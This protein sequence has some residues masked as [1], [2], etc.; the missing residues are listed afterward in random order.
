M[1]PST[2]YPISPVPF[3]DVSI[4]DAFWQP[5]LETNRKV[6][7]PYCFQKC[8]ET[9]R[10]ANFDKAAGVISGAHEG[11]FFNDS[12]V[13]KVLEGAAYALALAPD[14]ELDA[15]VDDLIARIEAAQEEDG[16]LYTART[17][18]PEAVTAESEGLTRW[19]N[20]PVNHELYNVGHMYEAAVAHF[21]AT[22]KRN[23]LDIA[24]RNAD[25]ID[26]VFGPDGIH[27]VP[28]HQEIEL[29][30]VKLYLVTGEQKYLN[31]AYFFLDQRGRHETRD[32]VVRFEN[33]GY[34]QD[35]LPVKEQASAV[36]HAVRAGYMYA[37]MA[38]V[39]ALC[40]EESWVKALET[41]WQDVVQGK[42]YLNGGIGARHQ[43]EAFGESFELPNDTGYAETCAAISNVYW[44]HRMFLLQGHAKA[45]DVLELSLYNGVLPGISLEGTEFFYSNPLYSD[46]EWEFNRG[47]IG[48]QP[49]FDCSCCPTNLVRFLPA[50]PGWIYATETDRIYVNLYVGSNTT[51]Q[52]PGTDAVVSLTQTTNYPWQGDVNFK[53]QLEGPTRFAL[54]LRVPGWLQEP[55]PGGLYSYVGVENSSWDLQRN[56]KRVEGRVEKGY[57]LVEEEWQDGDELTVEWPMP[58]RRVECHP[59][60]ENNQGRQALMRGPLVYCVEAVDNDRPVITIKLGED[61][62]LETSQGLKVQDGM[63][64]IQGRCEEGEF[65]AIPYHLWAHRGIGH[66]EVW[67]PTG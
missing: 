53:L 3:T 21:Q 23:F 52:V 49:W 54:A 38:D 67:L 33:P 64:S 65:T 5:R 57:V 4:S 44:N 22:G 12:D 46:G 19:S 6:T 63:V 66:M 8:E 20:L 42:L 35:H 13:Y 11:I 40:N 58:I 60:V 25:L 1:V 27:D 7:L 55:A 28:G 50:L 45:I 14:S 47:T 34:L 10:V 62:Q 61:L 9:N 59:A 24:L 17:I 16:Y 43:G 29:G 26:G 41:L 31:L 48:R 18:N 39:A 15:Y 30:L 36:G 37:G 56:G 2:G 32:A 51:V